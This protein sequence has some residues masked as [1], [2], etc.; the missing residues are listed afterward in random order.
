MRQS[1]TIK[2]K[3][4]VILIVTS[5]VAL[6]AKSVIQGFQ[7]YSTYRDDLASDM[8][9]LAEVIANNST[10]ALAFSDVKT[11]AEVLSALR[12]VPS[13][14]TAKLYDQIGNEFAAYH[15]DP[16]TNAETAPLGREGVRFEK[17]RLNLIRN[18]MLDN[19]RVGTL[20]IQSDLSEMYSRFRRSLFG[21]ALSLILAGLIALLL[22]LRLHRLIAEPLLHLTSTSRA[23]AEKNDYSLRAV[24]EDDDEIGELVTSFNHM[25]FQIQERDAKL[26]RAMDSLELRVRERTKQLERSNR[27]L[28]QFANVIS[29]DLQEPLRKILAFGTRLIGEGTDRLTD[30]QRDSLKRM[31]NAASRMEQLIQDLLQFSRIS[32]RE[33]TFQP[34]DLAKLVHEVLSDL[35][36]RVLDTRGKV[37]VSDLPVIEADA[38]QMRQLFQNLIANALKFYRKG[39]PPVVSVTSRAVGP[40]V[41]EITVQDN[42]IGFDEKYLEKIFKPFQRLHTRE[43]YEGTGMGLAI[44]QKIIFRHHGLITARSSLGVGSTFVITLP[45]KQ[46]QEEDTAE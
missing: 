12:S 31:Q 43:E 13:V 20:F 25:L 37:E 32:T 35:E 18:V 21:H 22:S 11:G 42:G 19:E 24:K 5:L 46:P 30:Q 2:F 40:N 29:H 23:I 15:R 3:L 17:S 26:T 10:A 41:L 9:T 4:M 14:V 45:I 33:H 8:S 1:R 34:V 39:T 28:Q 6:F 38:L 44:C 7:D 16:E 36:V 27:E